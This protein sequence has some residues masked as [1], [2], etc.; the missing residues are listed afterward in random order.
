LQDL[1]EAYSTFANYGNRYTCNFIKKLKINGKTVYTRPTKG[2]KIFQEDTAYLM[3]DILK[4]TAQ[5]GTAKKLRSLPFEIAAK[6]GTVGTKNGNTD[7][8]ALSYTV[9]DTIGVW[10]GNADNHF[11]DTTGGGLPCNLLLTL[12]ELLAQEYDKAQRKIPNFSIPK[13]VQ[14]VA[15]DKTAYYD[16][17]TIQLAD[18]SAPAE[19]QFF[20]LFKTSAIPLNKS[21]SFSNPQIITPTISLT[22]KGVRIHFDNRSPSYY[23]YRIER[24][25]Y[26][27]HTTLFV[28]ALGDTFIDENVLPNK[29]Y[30]YSVTPI[31][32]GKEGE[33]VILPSITTKRQATIPKEWWR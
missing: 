16:T 6:T 21:T 14:K 26:A 10:F 11:I 1:T 17:H 7:A 9:N 33:K 27:T 5:K 30:V 28:G 23:Q 22:E 24:Y 31:Y 12:N 4:S 20:E 18:D 19:Y 3:T 29:N 8:Y 25:D 15:L 32:N 13:N 2:I